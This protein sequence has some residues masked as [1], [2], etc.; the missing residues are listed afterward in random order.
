MAAESFNSITG[1]S[2]GIPPV[3]VIDSTGN[4]TINVQYPSGNVVVNTVKANS[5]AYAN[6][7]PIVVPS[8]SNTQIQFNDNGSF[9]GNTAFTFNKD[10][11]SVTINGNLIANSLQIG[12]GAYKFST[13]AVYFAETTSTAA[14]QVIWSID[15]NTVSGV[16][17]N[18]NAT[19]ATNDARHSLM[20]ASVNLGTTVMFTE[21]A[22][23]GINGGVGIFAVQYTAGFI[24]LTVTPY[25]ASSTNYH[26]SITTYAEY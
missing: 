1:Y 13:Q 20:I 2:V 11:V 25:A 14:D 15:A 12:F 7:S 26:M 22:G 17:F 19:D 5:Y 18:I 23:L 8:G 16:D 24:Q 21:Y 9:A 6:G 3:P 10:N 4:L